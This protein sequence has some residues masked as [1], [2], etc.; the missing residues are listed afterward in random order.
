MGLMH[1]E[2]HFKLLI[3]LATTFHDTNVLQSVT[4][5][6]LR[7]LVAFQLT[8]DAVFLDMS[9]QLSQLYL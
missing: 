4:S 5:C 8:T 3:H 7:M 2:T 6:T 9:W 1:S